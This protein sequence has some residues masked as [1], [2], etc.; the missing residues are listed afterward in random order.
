MCGRYYIPEEDSA[1]ELQ[2]IIDEINRKH[3]DTAIKTGEIRPTDVAPVIANS[4]S[5]VASAFAMR[6]GYSMLDGKTVFN[7][8]SE[9]AATRPMFQDGMSQRRCLVPAAYY[10]EWEKS[11]KERVKYAIGQDGCRVLYMAGIYRI[12]H[13]IPAFTILTRTPANNISSIHDRMPVILPIEAK[14]DWLN[15]KFMA[16]EIIR[17]A[18]MDVHFQ[19]V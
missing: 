9:T 3:G 17:A 13:G 1:A 12:E 10:F 5:M 18:V 2:A 6:W 16:D 15:P 7:A 19:A 14:A 11:G 4:R 8:R